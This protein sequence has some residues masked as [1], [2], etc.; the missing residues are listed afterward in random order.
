MRQLRA[1]A[2]ALSVHFS[3]EASAHRLLSLYQRVLQMEKLAD[4]N[5]V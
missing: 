2:R 1:G 4:R 3:W 5:A